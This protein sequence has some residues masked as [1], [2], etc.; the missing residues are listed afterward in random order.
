MKK[1]FGLFLAVIGFQFA[2]AQ[3]AVV[4]DKIVGI[5][6]DKII[7]K[8]DI[9]N[10][11][12]DAK[13]QGQEVPPEGN[14]IV[15]QQALA[16]KALVLQAE[17]DS[18]VISEEE[19]DALLENQIRSFIQAYGS[20]EAL[21][22]IAGRTI[23]QLKEDFRQPFRE[24]K[25]AEMMRN[26]IVENVKITPNEVKEYFEQIPKDS[27]PFYESELE[28]G[29]IVV[30]PKASR[31]IEKLAID[32]LNEYKK[33]IESGTRKIETLASL[34]SDDPGS[35]DRKGE[36]TINRNEKS[37]DPAFLNAAFR[38]KE[39]QVSQVIK[40]KFGYHIIQ[41]MSRAGDDAV[42][43]HILKIPQ[44]TETEVSEST[45]HLDSV[46]AKLLAGVLNFGEAVS[47]YSDDDAHKF[48]GGIRQC[49]NGNYC[50]IDELDKDVV[51]LLKNL[52]VGEYSQ[53][54]PFADE[55]GRRGVRI[56]YLKTRTEPHRENLKD[57]YNR[58]SQ[59]A[60]EI[61][62]E[63][64]LEKWFKKSIPTYYIMID[65]EFRT[66][67]MLDTWLSVAKSN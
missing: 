23:Y 27:L 21:E 56:V 34:Y 13:R 47:R 61:K 6:G 40:S 35:K 1:F 44:V 19:I 30:F 26:T 37:W 67:S 11:I 39:G 29:E 66:C 54:T 51:V 58:I 4:A 5:V 25:L 15:M 60:L 42:V 55:R 28:L 49:R 57:D 45:R 63:E 8:S 3:R 18:L 10:A 62:K 59:R 7:L 33:Q 48:T 17:K 41:M 46:R 14:C 36:Y 52:R 2:N 50:M 65:E 64:T 9:T 22:Q 53:P 43:R 32:E 38:L 16:Q 31:D 20:K 12:A 24:R